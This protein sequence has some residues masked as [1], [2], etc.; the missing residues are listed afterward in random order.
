VVDLIAKACDLS[1]QQAK[2]HIV[3]ETIKDVKI[4]FLSIEWLLKTKQSIREKDAIDQ[5]F[6]E[7]ILKMRK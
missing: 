2:D 5:K 3:F 1:Y 4:P 6:L 7:N